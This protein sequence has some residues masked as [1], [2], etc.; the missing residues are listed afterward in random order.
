[1]FGVT[2]PCV[3][4]VTQL[5]EDEYDCL[6]FHATGTGGQ[7]MEKLAD[8]GLLAGVHRRH[9]HRDRRRDRRRRALGRPRAARRVR[10]RTRCPTSARAARSTWSTSGRGTRCRSASRAASSTRHNPN[11]TLMRTTADECR[12][13]RRVHRAQAQRDARAGAL[14]D[15]R[16]RRLRPRRAGPAVLRSRGRPRAVRRHRAAA[17][18]PA[19]T[20]SACPRCRTTSTTRRSPMRWSPL[21]RGR[22]AR[23]R[24]RAAPALRPRTT[25]PRIARSEILATLARHDRARPAHHRRRRRHRPVGQVRGGRRHRPDRH[26]QL[27]PLPHGGPRL[28]RRA[29]RLRQRQRDRHARWR[30]RCCRWCSTRRCWPASTAPIRSCCATIPAAAGR[31]RLLGRAELPDGRPDRRHVPRQPRRDRHGLR[32]R[33]RDDRARP[34][35]STC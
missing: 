29:A 1:M 9:H 33:G 26:L 32:P 15:S 25:M 35:S 30:A 34:A 27:G 2:T 17:S 22:G 20:A 13:H 8:S 10:A 7:S 5:L 3:Q 4:A 11:V 6:V 12:A 19:P 24:R 16:R 14:P 23:R 21:P 18:A 31:A 28:A